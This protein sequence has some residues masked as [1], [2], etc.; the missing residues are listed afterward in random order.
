ME[1]DLCFPA[2]NAHGEVTAKEETQE[3]VSLPRLQEHGDHAAG[4]LLRAPVTPKMWVTAPKS[5]G[6]TQNQLCLLKW[7]EN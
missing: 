7:L 2:C 3:V 4:A 5:P 6:V 1:L